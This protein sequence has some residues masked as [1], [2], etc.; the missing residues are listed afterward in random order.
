MTTAASGW[1]A[2]L[3]DN[4]RNTLADAA[5]FQSFVG[6][7]TQAAALKKIHDTALPPPEDGSAYT[8][9]EIDRRIPCAVLDFAGQDAARLTVISTTDAMGS[10]SFEIRLY[11]D[12]TAYIA[13]NPEE[14]TRRALNDVGTIA[15]DLMDLMLEKAGGHVAGREVVIA[16]RPKRMSEAQTIAQG[17]YWEAILRVVL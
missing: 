17:E 13:D 15:E 8:A 3:Q 6:V 2:T 14:W 5:G 10:G 9:D 1:L 16:Q 11:D 12:V 4:M 7:S